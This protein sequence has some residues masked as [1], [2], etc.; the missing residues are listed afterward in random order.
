[1]LQKFV[2]IQRLNWILLAIGL[3]VILVLVVAG[4]PSM[5][6]KT[7]LM[8]LAQ[9]SPLPTPDS[10][11]TTSGPGL[12]LDLAHK[13]DLLL[14]GGVLLVVVLATGLVIWRHQ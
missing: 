5:P 3:L 11:S 10:S 14:I 9:E 12:P 8:V 7:G 6:G 13:M 1:M 2:P 4:P